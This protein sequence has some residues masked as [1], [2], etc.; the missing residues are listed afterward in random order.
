LSFIKDIFAHKRQGGHFAAL[1]QPELLL[2][3]L[4]DFVR[5]VWKK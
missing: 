3:D 1:E 5:Q 2:G 4:E